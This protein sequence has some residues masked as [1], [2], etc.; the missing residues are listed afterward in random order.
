MF[1]GIVQAVGRIASRTDTGGDLKLVVDTGALSERVEAARLA[2]GES[3]AV[4]GVCLTVIAFA[5]N[6]FTADVSR[7]TLQRTTLAELQPGAA[8]NLEAALRVG[9]PL[10]GHLMSGHV[11]GIA[12][13]QGVKQDGGSLRVRVEVP[14]EYARYIASKGSVALDGISLTVNAVQDTTFDVNLIPHTREMTNL[15]DLEAGRRLN[16]EVDSLARYAERVLVHLRP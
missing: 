5:G 12:V 14:A 4:N 7:E 16:L 10:G 13:V 2:I 11:D 1:T 8:V 9:D 6:Q 15:T 3:I